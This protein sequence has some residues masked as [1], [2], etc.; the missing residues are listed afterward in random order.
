MS[1]QD[2]AEQSAKYAMRIMELEKEIECRKSE[3]I[4]A[5]NTAFFFGL[6]FG[7]LIGLWYGL[8]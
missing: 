2:V 3:A 4:W 1:Y 6:M 5:E 7:A 8:Q